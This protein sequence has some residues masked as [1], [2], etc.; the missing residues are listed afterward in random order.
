MTTLCRDCDLVHPATRKLSPFKWVCMF[1]R[2][3]NVAD[4]RLTYVDPDWR[5]DPPYDRC[6]DHNP[7]GRCDR[8]Q[9][10]REPKGEE[11]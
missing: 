5:P 7:Y 6:I 8:F 2:K 11:Q 4:E 9:P 10:R 1:Y 3:P